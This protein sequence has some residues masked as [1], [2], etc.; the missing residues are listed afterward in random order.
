L[1]WAVEGLF[2]LLFRRQRQLTAVLALS[3]NCSLGALTAFQVRT[4]A[5]E[6]TLRAAVQLLSLLRMP[7]SALLVPF[8][9]KG[10]A[11]QV[12]AVV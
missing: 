12:P 5:L 2:V 1:C 9:S 11:F 8:A 7:C 10:F 6:G 4:S 3:C